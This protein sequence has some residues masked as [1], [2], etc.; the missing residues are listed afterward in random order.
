[1]I[2]FHIQLRSLLIYISLLEQAL[3]VGSQP[4]GFSLFFFFFYNL[5]NHPV[6]SNLESLLFANILCYIPC[7]QPGNPLINCRAT[8]FIQ[9][10]SQNQPLDQLCL[11]KD[12]KLLVLIKPSK[13]DSNLEL[14]TLTKGE[15]LAWTGYTESITV[16]EICPEIVKVHWSSEKE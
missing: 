3:H 7:K 6:I 15:L 4:P 12:R 8:K 14:D 16:W 13:V 9:L 10:I 1:L 11:P 2:S 5:W